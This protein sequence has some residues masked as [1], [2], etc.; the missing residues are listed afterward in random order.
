[1][2]RLF[3][4]KG[5]YDFQKVLFNKGCFLQG[6]FLS[7]CN[8]GRTMTKE[9]HTNSAIFYFQIMLFNKRCFFQWCFFNKYILWRIGTW[10]AYKFCSLENYPSLLGCKETTCLFKFHRCQTFRV[11]FTG[12]FITKC[13]I[14]ITRLCFILIFHTISFHINHYINFLCIPCRK[15]HN[16]QWECRH[17][18]ALST[19]MKIKITWKFYLN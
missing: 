13:Y 9:L 4:G 14:L 19:L 18:C 16:Q 6:C 12:K 1:M 8:L 5:N 11:L 2:W 7:K 15:I 3:G 17:T 10:V